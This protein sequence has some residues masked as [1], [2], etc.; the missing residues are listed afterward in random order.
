MDISDRQ[1][2]S[3]S[4]VHENEGKSPP[5][6]PSSRRWTKISTVA[7]TAACLFIAVSLYRFNREWLNRSGLI[8][9]FISSFMIAPEL[10]GEKRLEK[11]GLLIHARILLLAAH[12]L[13]RSA[14]ID[15]ISAT[16]LTKAANIMS[17]DTDYLKGIYL[18]PSGDSIEFDELLKT[19]VSITK[20]ILLDKPLL[21][22]VMFLHRIWDKTFGKI[23]YFIDN[24]VRRLAKRSLGKEEFRSAIIWW[25]ILL[26]ILG[27]LFQ[28]LSTF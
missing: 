16:Y 25:G 22:I 4:L 19:I 24:F 2:E 7:G 12:Q 6:S 15:M 10:I 21:I 3:L 27:N 14:R 8:F 5:G 20:I 1:E 26:F 13:Q 28:L 23:I 11:A 9:S 18:N 17:K